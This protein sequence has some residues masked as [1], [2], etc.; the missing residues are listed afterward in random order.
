VSARVRAAFGAYGVDPARLVLMGAQAG[1]A[2]HLALYNRVDVALD[3]FPFTGNQTTLEALWMGVPVVTLR[4]DR[5]LGRFGASILNHAGLPHLV[6][7]DVES[8][9]AIACRQMSDEAGRAELRSS[10]RAR[11]TASPLCDEASYV[12]SVEAAYRIMW[13]RW[14]TGLATPEQ[15]HL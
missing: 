3:P 7:D 15:R 9:L 8:Y 1:T 10:L 13:R 12:R 5:Y 6:A 14:C 11:L 2:D 4:G